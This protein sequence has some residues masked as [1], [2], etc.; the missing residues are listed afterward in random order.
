MEALNKLKAV[1]C[2]PDGKCCISGSPEDRRIVDECLAA[3]AA[4]NQERAAVK[5]GLVAKVC[6]YEH[7]GPMQYIQVQ[8]GETLPLGMSLFATP[9][10]P[11]AE[12]QTNEA[13]INGVTIENWYCYGMPAEPLT[14][15]QRAEIIEYTDRFEENSYSR[16]ELA[17]MDDEGIVAAAYS[18][19]ADY[20]RGQM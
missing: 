17:V 8:G 6:N 14:P 4:N 15:D 12:G 19:M 9:Q 3:L 16:E 11:A 18:A 7:E 5:E 20:A 13:E 1:L 10:P 2:G